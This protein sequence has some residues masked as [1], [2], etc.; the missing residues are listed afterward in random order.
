MFRGLVYQQART[1]AVIAVVVG[2]V[3]AAIEMA[4]DLRSER[5]NLV[6][7]TKQILS[8]INGSAADAAFQMN[9]ELSKDL[10]DG[11]FHSNVV[12]SAT[13]LD[14]FGNEMAHKERPA[15]ENSLT[16]LADQLFADSTEF[17]L[18]LVHKTPRGIDEIVGELDVTLDPVTVASSFFDR[19]GMSLAA[20]VARVVSICLLIV[21]AFTLMI[22]RPLLR[23]TAGIGKVD[24]E[25]PGHAPLVSPKGHD[26]D[27]LGLLVGTMNSLLAAFQTGLDARDTAQG[28]LTE[29]AQRTREGQDTL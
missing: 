14:N 4:G 25:N 12:R 9:P 29:L 7:T 23:L 13:M 6:T 8:M 24:P 11:L 15:S 21:A 5:Q 27:E 28:E 16:W 19:A 10:V 1:V 2:F 22:T 17:D 18:P 20:T 3:S 26:D